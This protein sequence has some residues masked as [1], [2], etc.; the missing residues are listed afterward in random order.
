M[1]VPYRLVLAVALAICWVADNRS[2]PRV[3]PGLYIALMFVC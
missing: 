1:G 2:R 3:P